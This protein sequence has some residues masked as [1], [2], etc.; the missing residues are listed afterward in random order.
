MATT[1]PLVPRHQLSRLTSHSQV[2]F[3]AV[4]IAITSPS[5]VKRL[6][7]HGC[8]PGQG[9]KESRTQ[10]SLLSTAAHSPSG[11]KQAIGTNTEPDVDGHDTLSMCP[12]LTQVG[13]GAECTT[14]GGRGSHGRGR[15]SRRRNAAQQ[16]G[17]Q[18]A[19][20]DALTPSTS[21]WD[22]IQ[23]R[24]FKVV[25]KGKMRPLG[26]VLTQSDWCPHEKRLLGHTRT[27]AASRGQ[28]P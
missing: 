7:E 24:A 8:A 9:N 11:N 20:A 10:A 5:F 26:W 13:S 19:S 14:G 16:A 28:T 6:T 15:Q 25:V 1:T 21:Q 2:L 22:C 18:T 3:W 4:N 12:G 27:A 23:R 17:R